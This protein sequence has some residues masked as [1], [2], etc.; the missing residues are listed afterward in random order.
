MI[1]SLGAELELGDRPE[2][3]HKVGYLFTVVLRGP[4]GF[5]IMMRYEGRQSLTLPEQ[6]NIDVGKNQWTFLDIAGVKK[7]LA[8][9]LRM[10]DVCVCDMDTSRRA[11]T[12]NLNLGHP[13]TKQVLDVPRAIMRP[14]KP[15]GSASQPVVVPPPPCATGPPITAPPARKP[16]SKCRQGEINGHDAAHGSFND[17]PTLAR[18]AWVGRAQHPRIEWRNIYW[19]IRNIPSWHH[20][21][22]VGSLGIRGTAQRFASGNRGAYRLR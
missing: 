22:G 4:N 9:G 2:E 6:S 10:E 3:H 15:A 1:A 13:P 12:L 17:E 19:R 20:T 18:Q 21:K 11:G 16:V 14:L 8:T 5:P 7:Y